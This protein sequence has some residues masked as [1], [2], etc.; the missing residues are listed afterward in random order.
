MR[1]QKSANDKVR[2]QIGYIIEV[3]YYCASDMEF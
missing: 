2:F 3:S 1:L